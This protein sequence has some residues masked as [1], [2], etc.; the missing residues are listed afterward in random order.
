MY[1]VVKCKPT[2]NLCTNIHPEFVS[3]SIFDAKESLSLLQD[4][5][6]LN[7]MQNSG[8]HS[9]KSVFSHLYFFVV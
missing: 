2:I 5:L 9:V 4:N 6:I 7:N 3:Y 1:F 8:I